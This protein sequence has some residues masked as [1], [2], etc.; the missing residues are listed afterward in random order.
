MAKQK[1]ETAAVDGAALATEVDTAVEATPTP[2]HEQTAQLAYSYWQAR[3]CPDGSP[4]DDW[5]R[6][7]ADLHNG[8]R[9]VG[10]S[11]TATRT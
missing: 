10:A 9:T 6:A 1:T 11:Q 2:D 7:E 4:E 8:G 3:G 5:F